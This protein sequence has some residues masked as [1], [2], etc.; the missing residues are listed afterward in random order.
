MSGL[1]GSITGCSKTFN[2]LNS[3]TIEGMKAASFLDT[4]IKQAEKTISEDQRA[5]VVNDKNNEE[6]AGIVGKI[7]EEMNR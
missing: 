7:E 1:V 5:S 6:L 3:S 4:Q 2:E